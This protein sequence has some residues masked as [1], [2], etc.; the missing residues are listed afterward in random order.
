MTL[1]FQL[2]DAIHSV[3]DALDL[4]PGGIGRYLNGASIVVSA[5]GY[6]LGSISGE[7][8]CQRRLGS[9]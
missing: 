5:Q 9:G 6:P 4:G 1:V 7:E 8:L 3:G 2:K